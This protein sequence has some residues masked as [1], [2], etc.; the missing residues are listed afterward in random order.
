MTRRMQKKYTNLAKAHNT[1][2]PT[3]HD[4]SNSAENC[5]EPWKYDNKYAELSENIF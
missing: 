3:L 2:H 1:G 5:Y 4:A